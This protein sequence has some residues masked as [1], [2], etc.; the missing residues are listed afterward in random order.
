MTHDDILPATRRRFLIET[1]VL[2]GAGIGVAL[3]PAP[4]SATPAS[5][6]AAIRKVVGEAPIKQGKVKL[7]LP[8]LIENGNAVPLTVACESPMTDEDHVKAI[9]VFTEKNPQPN[10][11]S[12]ALGPRAGRAS[13]STRIRLADSQKLI[14]IAQTSDGSFWSAEVDVVVTLAACLEGAL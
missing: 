1:A 14:A 4:A 6:R 10:V 11:V 13:V 7:D 2:V 12:I 5:M 9:H 3:A 8:P